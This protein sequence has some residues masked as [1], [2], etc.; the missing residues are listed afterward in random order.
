MGF[1]SNL[2]GQAKELTKLGNAVANVKNMLDK[3]EDD[4][5][6]SFLVV[7]SWICKVGVKDMIQSNHWPPNYVVYVPIDGHQT[8]MSMA[9]V[10]LSTIERLMKKVSDLE[11]SDFEDK[12]MDVLNGGPS[13][14]EID[15]QLPR[16]IKDIIEHPAYT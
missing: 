13:F 1:F 6:V 3:Y 15:S 4:N 14:F 2:F 11:D 9:E 8:K 12:I 10:Q 16:Q 7:A 5:D